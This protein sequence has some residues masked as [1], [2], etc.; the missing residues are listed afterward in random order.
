MLSRDTLESFMFSWANIGYNFSRWFRI[1]LFIKSES[2]ETLCRN[3]D[4][5]SSWS[6]L[7]YW[8]IPPSS[9]VNSVSLSS[10]GK[11]S[12]AFTEEVMLFL[13]SGDISESEILLNSISLC[14]NSNWLFFIFNWLISSLN[15]IIIS[16]WFEYLLNN[17]LFLST[18]SFILSSFL[19]ISWMLYIFLLSNSAATFSYMV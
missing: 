14:I 19:R 11:R 18:T 10:S 8:V 9:L 4:L 2:R 5:L 16:S 7:R 15:L 6:L 17:Y 3:P 12:R 1:M 13:L